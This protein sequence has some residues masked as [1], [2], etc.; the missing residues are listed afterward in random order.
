MDLL[1]PERETVDRTGQTIIGWC[2]IVATAIAV[3]AVLLDRFRA[4]AGHAVWDPEWLVAAL[5]LVLAPWLFWIGW[6]L[7]SG[8][9]DMRALLPPWGLILA[10]L[11]ME[12][13]AIIAH[14]Q[15]PEDPRPLG[16]LVLPGLGALILGLRRWRQHRHLRP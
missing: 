7:I 8:R 14:Q 15:V 9:L 12:A 2:L 1:D 4:V 16:W 5:F 13:L 3:A 6:R 10:G 11:S